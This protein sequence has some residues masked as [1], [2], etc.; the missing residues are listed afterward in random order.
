MKWRDS[1]TKRTMN[2]SIKGL[3]SGYQPAGW[4]VVPWQLS[5]YHI[6][7]RNSRTFLTKILYLNLGCVVYA[8]IQFYLNKSGYTGNFL[9]IVL[10]A[11]ITRVN[12]VF[13]RHQE[14]TL[15]CI[16]P[17]SSGHAVPFIIVEMNRMWL[18]SCS[19]MAVILSL[20]VFSINRVQKYSCCIRGEPQNVLC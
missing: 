10:K 9:N 15:F 5:Q 6:Y 18:Y 7:L 16:C 13:P 17:C 1:E 3:H 11:W 4:K 2:I 12:T 20:C 14:F 8:R 19:E